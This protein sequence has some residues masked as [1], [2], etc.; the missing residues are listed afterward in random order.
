MCQKPCYASRIDAISRSETVEKPWY[1][2]DRKAWY[3][4]VYDDGKR[5]KRRIG[6]TK[7]EA[8]D[9]WRSLAGTGNDPTFVEIRTAF[10]T[11]AINQVKN[12]DLELNTLEN[13][14]WYADQF[15]K[16]SGMLR[17]SELAPKH[18]TDWIASNPTWGPSAQRHAIIT[19]NRI[20][21]WSLSERR[22]TEN[23]FRGIKKPS[24]KRR[25]ELIPSEMHELMVRTAGSQK[26]SGKIDRQF[27]LV[28]VAL[29][30]CGG[31]PQD[32]ANV[33]IEHCSD[34]RWTVHEH[35]TKRHTGR[36]RIVYLSPCLQTI[37]KMLSWNRSSGPLF[38][39]RRGSLTTNA[40]GCRIKRLREEL[41]ISDV[42]AYSYRHTYITD[43][44]QRGVDIATVA[45]L[46]GTSVSMIQRHYGHLERKG[47]HLRNAA[48][49]AVVEIDR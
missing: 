7:R 21:N 38:R 3:L 10:F 18:V 41:G 33:R 15:E 35:K 32:V 44:M 11:W 40:I 25:E 6:S 26:G 37:T 30:H 47:D 16:R 5:R 19:V 24:G 43:A 45:E 14:A 29:R 4:W 20:A 36:P 13:Y 2:K 48:I 39:G 12:G 22:I 46:V 23:P 1:Y 8:Y 49:R 31:R 34:D 42:V 17:I 27:R 28:L 9:Y